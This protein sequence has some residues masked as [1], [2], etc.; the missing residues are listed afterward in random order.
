M[1]ARKLF[2]GIAT[3][4]TAAAL[5]IAPATAHADCGDDEQPACT[6]PV[7]SVDRVFAIMAELT[8]SSR[9]AASKTD[10]VAPGCAPDETGTIDN[11]LNSLNSRGSRSAECVSP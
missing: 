3:A 11:H 4:T 7:P 9:P 10:V 8:D 1:R 6:G 2:S 5:I